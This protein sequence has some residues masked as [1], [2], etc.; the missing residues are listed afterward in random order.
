LRDDARQI[1]NY[2]IQLDETDA[3]LV[4]VS[5]PWIGMHTAQCALLIAPYK[6][7][8]KP[9]NSQALNA[10]DRG[11]TLPASKCMHRYSP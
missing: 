6:S 1:I 4:V 11:E 5:L 9:K 7:R 3:E 2:A 10:P 8:Q